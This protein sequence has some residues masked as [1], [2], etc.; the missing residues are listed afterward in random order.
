MTIAHGRASA[1]RA[2]QTY[3]MAERVEES[4]V[5]F[6]TQPCILYGDERYDYAD[7]NRRINQVAHRRTRWACAATTWWRCAW[8]TARPSLFAWLGLAKLGAP[9]GVSRHA[10]SVAEPLAHALQ[11]TGAT[12]VVVGEEC[13][14]LFAATELPSDPRLLALAGR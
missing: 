8:K 2:S 12:H 4:A 10:T 7:T 6:A 1:T 5:R 11:V 14:G 9:G 3:T 13:L